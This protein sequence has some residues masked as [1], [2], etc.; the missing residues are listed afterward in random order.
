MLAQVCMVVVGYQRDGK[1]EFCA[2]LVVPGTNRCKEHQ[3]SLAEVPRPKAKP[4]ER[5]KK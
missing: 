4:A 1:R 5:T 3:G 2:R